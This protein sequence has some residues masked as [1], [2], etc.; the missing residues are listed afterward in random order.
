MGGQELSSPNPSEGN[1]QTWT[2]RKISQ[3]ECLWQKQEIQN[4]NKDLVQKPSII[5]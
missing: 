4:N 3:K 1:L 5:I 2:N